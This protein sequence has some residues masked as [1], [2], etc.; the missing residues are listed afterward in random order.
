VLKVITHDHVGAKPILLRAAELAP[1]DAYNYLLLGSIL[2]DEY[3]NQAKIYQNMPDSQA[4][5]DA[6]A[7]VLAILDSVIDAYAHMIALSEGVAPLQPARQQCLQDIEGYYKYRHNNST[8]GM[9]QLIDKYKV[10]AKP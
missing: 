6:L 5:R 4:K 7:K 3:Q 1:T 10:A 8:A 2:D 9:Q